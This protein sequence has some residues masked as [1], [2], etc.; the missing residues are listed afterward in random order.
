MPPSV[1]LDE[2]DRFVQ[3]VLAEFA[4]PHL[5]NAVRFGIRP[6]E[7]SAWQSRHRGGA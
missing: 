4:A 3:L 2:Q 7:F 1:P 5:G 6:L